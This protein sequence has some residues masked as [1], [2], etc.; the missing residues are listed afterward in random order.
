MSYPLLVELYSYNTV[1][2]KKVR[3]EA[4]ASFFRQ[5]SSFFHT[6]NI[7]WEK[8]RDRRRVHKSTVRPRPPPRRPHI[9]K[10]QHTS[11]DCALEETLYTPSLP[12]FVSPSAFVVCSRSRRNHFLPQRVTNASLLPPRHAPPPPLK[13]QKAR[14]VLDPS[15]HHHCESNGSRRT[16]PFGGR[17][18]R[19]HVRHRPTR[20]GKGAPGACAPLQ[21]R[22]TC[23]ARVFFSPPTPHRSKKKRKEK[24]RY[25]HVSA[26]T[27]TARHPLA[28]PSNTVYRLFDQ[29]T[30]S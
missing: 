14:S 8:Q 23:V 5:K 15:P 6:S 28:L 1:V 19:R 17:E 7:S 13:S 16:R 29:H 4:E 27:R 24:K 25:A 18:R 21:M 2:I 9:Y 20:R 10:Q 12:C 11:A 30:T 3:D 26:C 22:V